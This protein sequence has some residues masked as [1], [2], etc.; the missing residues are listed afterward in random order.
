VKSSV[1]WRVRYTINPQI[2]LEPAERAVPELKLEFH[3]GSNGLLNGATHTVTAGSRDDPDEAF[4]L[5]RLDLLT[6]WEALRYNSGQ[7][8]QVRRV[9]AE[10]EGHEVRQLYHKIKPEPISTVQAP[11]AARLADAPPELATWLWLANAAEHETDDASA[12]RAYYIILEATQRKRPAGA[13]E[14]VGWARD[15]V[16]HGQIT[17]PKAKAFLAKELGQASAEYRYNPHDRE[18][19]LLVRRFRLLARRAAVQE[20]CSYL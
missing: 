8:L 19:R 20:L 11:S 18:H 7:Q 2:E 12:L 17:K 1:E 10:T 16:S 14:G 5:S 6:Y 3:Y 13:L 15:F 9:F 4:E